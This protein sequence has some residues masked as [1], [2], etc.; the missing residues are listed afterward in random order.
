MNLCWTPPLSGASGTVSLTLVVSPLGARE[1]STYTGVKCS[2]VFMSVKVRAEF[3][4]DP[5]E[6]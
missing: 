5:I 4:A 3:T 1:C 6:L 2:N